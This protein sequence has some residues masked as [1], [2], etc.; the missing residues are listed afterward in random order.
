MSTTSMRQAVHDKMAGIAARHAADVYPGMDGTAEQL[1]ALL[2]DT[3]L[4]YQMEVEADR[5][6]DGPG[7]S[8]GTASEMT[9]AGQ[10]LTALAEN[11]GLKA[12]DPAATPVD[13]WAAWRLGGEPEGN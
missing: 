4:A 10:V 6:D 13:G 5:A 2:A 11:L 3:A 7:R 9:P 8:L 1:F 12:G